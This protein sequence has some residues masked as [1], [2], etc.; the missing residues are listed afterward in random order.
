MRRC[1]LLVKKVFPIYSWHQIFSHMPHKS[2]SR[3]LFAFKFRGYSVLWQA[4]SV[5]AALDTIFSWAC[6]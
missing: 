6:I 3:L 5:M 2:L 1:N 4:I